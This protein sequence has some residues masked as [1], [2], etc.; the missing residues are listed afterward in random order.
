VVAVAFES[1]FY[2]EMYQNNIFFKKII[3]DISAL[4]WSKNT[5]KLLIWNRKNKKISIFFKNIFKTQ[6]QTGP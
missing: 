1:G 2:S 3:S 6:K 5:K 4:K